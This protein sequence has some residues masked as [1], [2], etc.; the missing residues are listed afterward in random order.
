[1]VLSMVSCTASVACCTIFLR[2]F[3][4]VAVTAA[5][6]CSLLRVNTCPNMP[7][8]TVK[9]CSPTDTFALLKIRQS[10]TYKVCSSTALTAFDV[11]NFTVPDADSDIPSG[12]LPTWSSTYS[13]VTRVMESM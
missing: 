2:S 6:N 12:V 1:M 10:S 3:S 5:A 4:M 13:V 9:V 11:A 8:P 7:M